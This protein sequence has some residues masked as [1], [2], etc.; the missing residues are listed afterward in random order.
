M[1][2]INTYVNS[3]SVV[4]DTDITIVNTDPYLNN[5]FP[6]IESRIINLTSSVTAMLIGSDVLPLSSIYDFTNGLTYL[7]SSTTGA[8]VPSGGTPGTNNTLS[9]SSKSGV[10]SL[11]LSSVS[12]YAVGF[13]CIGGT[14]NGSSYGGS[15]VSV[16]EYNY[17]TSIDVVSNT[18]TLELPISK[19]HF[20]GTSIK[21]FTLTYSRQVKGAITRGYTIVTYQAPSSL[22]GCYFDYVPNVSLNDYYNIDDFSLTWTFTIG[23][24]NTSPNN[25]TLYVGNGGDL[26]TTSLNKLVTIFYPADPLPNNVTHYRT[27]RISSDTISGNG[28]TVF[29]NCVNPSV[30]NGISSIP[31]YS[32]VII[33][34]GSNQVSGWVTGTN[35][36]FGQISIST[37][38]TYVWPKYSI[39]RVYQGT[40]TDV[41]A[42]PIGATVGNPIPQNANGLGTTLCLND[43]S[44]GDTQIKVVSTKGISK[45]IFISVDTGINNEYN[46]IVSNVDYINNIVTV[47]PGFSK[48]HLKNSC[49]FFYNYGENG[50]IP[51]DAT[52]LGLTTLY[53]PGTTSTTSNVNPINIYPLNTTVDVNECLVGLAIYGSIQLR[54]VISLNGTLS[55]NYST[56]SHSGSSYSMSGKLPIRFFS[57]PKL[58]SP[59]TLSGIVTL[60]SPISSGVNVLV[61]NDGTGKKRIP[62]SFNPSVGTMVIINPAGDYEESFISALSS[63]NGGNNNQLTLTST[64]TKNHP[65]DC[66]IFFCTLPTIPSSYNKI[67]RTFLTYGTSV[68][69]NVIYLN[70]VSGIIEGKTYVYIYN[71]SAIDTDFL[72]VKVSG[73]KVTLNKGLVYGHLKNSFVQVYDYGVNQIPNNTTVVS[74]TTLNATSGSNSGSVGTNVNI[75]G[76][77]TYIQSSVGTSIES[78]KLISSIGGG[79]TFSISPLT[80]TLTTSSSPAILTSDYVYPLNAILPGLTHNNVAYTAN[81]TSMTIFR[82]A[83][84]VANY[85]YV[86]MEQGITVERSLITNINNG[87]LTLATPFTKSFPIGTV[88]Q[89]YMFPQIPSGTTLLKQSLL[90]TASSVGETTL[91]VNSASGISPY[92]TG[93]LIAG[94]YYG[95]TIERRNVISVNSNTI[96]LDSSLEFAHNINELVQFYSVPSLASYA[97]YVGSAQLTSAV[98]D[99]GILLKVSSTNNLVAGSTYIQ[100]NTGSNLERNVLIKSINSTT[101]TLTTTKMKKYHNYSTIISY[102]TVPSTPLN[103][104]IV[105]MSTLSSASIVGDSSLQITSFTET[106]TG[107]LYAQ[108]GTGSTMENNIMVTVVSSTSITLSSS[109][110]FV[111]SLDE[112]IQFY[113]YPSLPSGSIYQGVTNLSSAYSSG[114]TITV[115]STTGITAGKYLQIGSGSTKQFGVLVSSVDGNTVTISY[116]LTNTYAS[117]TVVQVYNYAGTPTDTLLI[118]ST[119]STSS[120]S[121]STKTISVESTEGIVPKKTY[122]QIDAGDSFE[123]DFLVKSVSGSTVTLYSSFTKAHASGVGVQFYKFEDTPIDGSQVLS[124]TVA[125]EYI[126]GTS[127]TLE[128][129]SGVVVGKT[130]FLIGAS[131]QVEKNNLVTGIS[132]NTVTFSSPLLNTYAVGRRVIFYSYPDIP[133][134][135]TKL[136]TTNLLYNSSISDNQITLSSVTGIVSNTSYLQIGSGSSIEKNLLVIDISDNVVTLSSP[137]VY[138]HPVDSVVQNYKFP[139]LP[140]DT[141]PVGLYYTTSSITAGGSFV[142]LSSVSGLVAGNTYLQLGSGTNLESDLTVSSINTQ[143]KSVMVNPSFSYNR[144]TNIYIQAYSSVPLPIGATKVTMAKIQ[145]DALT[146]NFTLVANSVSGISAGMFI[147]TGSGEIYERDLK[148]TNVNTS[149]KEITFSPPFSFPHGASM[150]FQVYTYPAIP[151]NGTLLNVYPLTYANTGSSSIVRISTPH[152]ITDGMYVQIGYGF[153][154]ERF[155]VVS[156][157]NDSLLLSSQFTYIH[158]VGEPLQAYTFPS[159]IIPSGTI[160]STSTRFSSQVEIGSSVINVIDST[161]INV[162][163]N[164]ILNVDSWIETKIVV[165]ISGNNITLDSP[166]T[167][168]HITYSPVL[169]YSNTLPAVPSDA[170]TSPRTI[171]TAAVTSGSDKIVVSN[172]SSITVGSFILV[173]TLSLVETKLVLDI[174]GNTLTVDSNFDYAHSIYSIVQLYSYPDPAL[175]TYALVSSNI[176]SRAP[177]ALTYCDTYIPVTST[178]GIVSGTYMLIGVGTQTE[179][180]L[181]AGFDASLNRVYPE[182][183]LTKSHRKGTRIQSFQ[184]IHPKGSILVDHLGIY[185]YVVRGTTQ[186][187]GL[188]VDNSAC[189]SVLSQ[190]T[191]LMDS[192]TLMTGNSVAEST[193]SLLTPIKNVV[194]SKCLIGSIESTNQTVASYIPYYLTLMSYSVGIGKSA[195]KISNFNVYPL[196]YALWES[197]STIINDVVPKIIDE[198]YQTLNEVTESISV[199]YNLYD[200]LFLMRLALDEYVKT[201][202]VI[203]Y[204]TFNYLRNNFPSIPIVL[205]LEGVMIGAGINSINEAGTV[206]PSLV[207]SLK[208]TQAVTAITASTAPVNVGETRLQVPQSTGILIGQQITIDI[209]LAQET[210]TVVG[211]GSIIVYPPFKFPHAAGA[212]TYAFDTRENVVI[213]IDDFET[214][215]RLETAVETI[216]ELAITPVSTFVAS[217]TAPISLFRDRFMFGTTDIESY[218]LDILQPTEQ[219]DTQIATYYVNSDNWMDISSNP[220]INI[221]KLVCTNGVENVSTYISQTNPH[222]GILMTAVLCYFAFGIKDSNVLI[223]NQKEYSDRMAAEFTENI[224]NKVFYS[225]LWAHDFRR[226]ET[227]SLTQT[228][229]GN[230]ITTVPRSD[231]IDDPRNPGVKCVSDFPSTTV[232]NSIPNK[233]MH[234]IAEYDFQRVRASNLIPYVGLNN[235]Y[236]MPLV[237]GDVIVFKLKIKY[238]PNNVFSLFRINPNNLTGVSQEIIDLNNRL[239]LAVNEHTDYI[240]FTIQLTL[241]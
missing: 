38:P 186:N 225:L 150:P 173:D 106:Y 209:G 148:I 50:P 174:S 126:S 47:S 182:L 187:N 74:T 97:T 30:A 40:T 188:L 58:P 79:N 193:K 113:T 5:S 241:V 60:A 55:T 159:P 206:Y 33:G 42:T 41:A 43:I 37:T 95:S 143:L 90:T 224:W 11:T 177:S 153:G 133:E 212:P 70:S 85:T 223:K 215:F 166:T 152:S 183:P 28:G 120:V 170:V 110:S 8:Q 25:Q 7:Y 210:T 93:V 48:A 161:N 227:D 157:S 112:P 222:L 144:N 216:R 198:T 83:G 230:E 229:F 51:Q 32:Y 16:Y 235:V 228:I 61:I 167:K 236:Y 2:T 121:A 71:L 232:N 108:I 19:P 151:T 23:S 149:T 14:Y 189:A 176:K 59:D 26:L 129:T 102:Y 175:P 195:P 75:V 88:A 104:T 77:V 18:I 145:T 66:S 107:T 184:A 130:L 226:L 65:A 199:F 105:G 3:D 54:Q 21:Q 141:V 162:G 139:D 208:P 160:S 204:N 123:K 180:V 192:L 39:I 238:S 99:N 86:Q 138:S 4:I 155:L 165:D 233:M 136:S 164:L 178:T 46:L 194:E 221:S 98:N 179:V 135:S 154:I 124:T 156:V 20:I 185:Q 22:N 72:V 115:N 84:M 239:N 163:D 17:I 127:L 27:C 73:N 118:T 34:S 81:S 78:R 205:Y 142:Q 207:P 190:I 15:S 6:I 82:Q 80:F 94:G 219:T 45:N 131:T 89:T 117:G 200:N 52:M 197:L 109:L 218:M 237:V 214:E 181:I 69:D 132:G 140:S 213:V 134:N 1:A 111:H 12:G 13:V 128:S 220:L 10:N 231:L 168:K 36:T 147:T 116:P 62:S 31:L 87:V 64:L 169:Q 63:V 76:N 49:S 67:S 91:I 211:Y 240:S 158:A 44:I 217:G 203:N 56:L 234:Q 57:Y 146:G 29:A 172:V 137:L 92:T 191:T 196:V 103:S 35:S 125:S 171:T 24:I 119:L 122:M 101:N 53:Q 202:E 68:G 100:L 201:R 96:T 9:L 114:T